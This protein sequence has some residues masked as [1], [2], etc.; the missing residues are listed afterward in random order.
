MTGFYMNCNTGLKWVMR[1]L[2]N[3]AFNMKQWDD[4]H[5]LNETVPL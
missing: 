3:F 4:K 2:L 5:L 1:N